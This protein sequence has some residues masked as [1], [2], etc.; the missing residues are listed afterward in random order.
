MIQTKIAKILSPTKVVLSAG[1]EHGVL[2][3]MIF[4]IY[5]LGDAVQDPETREPLGQLELHKARIKVSQV[6][7][8]LSVATTLPRHVERNLIPTPS[9]RYT[10]T[11]YPALPL[12]ESVATAVV[13]ERK[14]TVKVGDLARSLD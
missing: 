6:Q 14:L 7:E 5:E 9:F 3:G 2:E 8:R 12:D 10:E 1:A 13:E 11:E 4:V